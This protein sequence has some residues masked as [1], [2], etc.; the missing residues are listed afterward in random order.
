MQ[1]IKFPRYTFT[2]SQALL[3]QARKVS[4]LEYSDLPLLDRNTRSKVLSERFSAFQTVD[5]LNPLWK[6]IIRDHRANFYRQWALAV[7][8]SCFMILPPLCLYKILVLLEHRTSVDSSSDQIWLW[9]ACLAVSKLI[10]FG[11]DTW[12]AASKFNL[13]YK[14]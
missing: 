5:F 6:A 13:L 7:V 4:R 9:V 11:L 3:R 2:W 14:Y 12:Y 1:R 10:H 8:E